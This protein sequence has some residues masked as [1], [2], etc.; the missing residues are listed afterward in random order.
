V[1]RPAPKAGRAPSIAAARS[2]STVSRPRVTV[3]SVAATVKAAM[4]A[5]GSMGAVLLRGAQGGD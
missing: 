4:A 3:G 2:T 5:T 1:P